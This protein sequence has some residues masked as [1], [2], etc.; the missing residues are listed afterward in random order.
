MYSNINILSLQV[1][2]QN[3]ALNLAVAYFF[4]VIEYNISVIS[5]LSQATQ[6]PAFNEMIVVVNCCLLKG[7]GVILLQAACIVSLLSSTRR[8]EAAP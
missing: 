1:N 4:Q 6:H 2:Q 3:A 8:G 5:K 7:F